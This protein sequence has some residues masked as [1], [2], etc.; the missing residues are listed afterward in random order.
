M[1][2]YVLNPS[3]NANNSLKLTGG[4]GLCCSD[5]ATPCQYTATYAAAGALTAITVKDKAGVNKTLTFAGVTGATNVRA[6]IIAAL[7]TAGIEDDQNMQW[8]GVVVTA[9]SSNLQVVITGEAPAVSLTHAGGTAN[10]DG[11]CKNELRCDYTIVGYAGGA[12][13]T[14][15]INGTDQALGAITPG[16]TSAGTVQT[17]VETALT[18]EGITGATVTVAT[19]GSGGSTLYNIT[20]RSGSTHTFTIG[21][22]HLD[23]GNC[24]SDWID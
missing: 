3:Q 13:N 9:V 10:F 8:K 21:G 7:K 15:H 4:D 11:D 23:R 6:A 16:T 2:K 17:A 18:N 22:T 14:L 19:T 20:I 1:L 12:T 24:V 5:S